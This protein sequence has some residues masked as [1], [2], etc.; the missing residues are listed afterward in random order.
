[1]SS[2]NADKM[3]MIIARIEIIVTI[4]RLVGQM[5]VVIYACLVCVEYS[6]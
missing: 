5:S 1:M 2:K 3:V 4:W 6:Q